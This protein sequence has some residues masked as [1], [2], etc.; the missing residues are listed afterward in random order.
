MGDDQHDPQEQSDDDSFSEAT[1]SV[2][3]PAD[4]ST[5]LERG[6]DMALR[7]MMRHR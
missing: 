6:T 5:P 7:A 3:P 1:D 2:E 4:A